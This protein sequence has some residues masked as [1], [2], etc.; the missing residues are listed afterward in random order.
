MSSAVGDHAGNVR[1]LAGKSVL[2]VDDQA[3][4][5]RLVARALD[6][7][8]NLTT[9]DAEDGS[10]ALSQL[11]VLSCDVILMDINMAPMHGLEALK[12][13]RTSPTDRRTIP[14]VMLTT[15]AD[16]RAVKTAVALGVS[17][18]IVKPTSSGTLIARLA[19]AIEKPPAMKSISHYETV[20]IPDLEQLVAK[21]DESE[22]GKKPEPDPA[23]RQAAPGH[24]IKKVA[25]EGVKD[26]D[27]LI[28]PVRT[29]KGVELVPAETMLTTQLASSLR[30]LKEFVPVTSVTV[31]RPV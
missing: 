27:R 15:V 9:Y 28:E 14:V 19:R 4:I 2:I 30:D 7:V 10:K 18:F 21:P 25:L 3:F 1:T 16:T 5:R 26:G 11:S 22:P 12:R 8:P 17:G 20:P 13:I 24:E 6:D 23:V 29:A 31:E